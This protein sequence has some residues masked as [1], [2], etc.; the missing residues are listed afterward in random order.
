MDEEEGIVTFCNASFGTKVEPDGFFY[1]GDEQP[2][3]SLTLFTD[4]GVNSV[5]SDYNV[6]AEYYNL[7][8]MRVDSPVSG[9]IYVKRQAGKAIK[10][11]VVR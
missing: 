3:G 6:T 8:G 1:W 7:Q 5:A 10:V 11:R 2:D 4:S 9:Q